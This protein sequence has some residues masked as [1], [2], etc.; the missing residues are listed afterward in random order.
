MTCALWSSTLLK[1]GVRAFGTKGELRVFNPTG[2]QFGYRM[3]VR[4]AGTKER[5][6]V[7]GAK[8][9]T[10][11]YQLRAFLAAVRDGDPA[12]HAT[13]RRRREHG[14]RRRDLPR[15]GPRCARAV[16]SRRL[17]TAREDPGHG[18]PSQCALRVPVPGGARARDDGLAA[19]RVRPDLRARR[20]RAGGAGPRADDGCPRGGAR[21]RWRDRGRRAAGERRL[22]L[23]DR[24]RRRHRRVGEPRVASPRVARPGARRDRRRV[25][26]QPPR[27]GEAARGELDT[28]PH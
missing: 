1:V 18:S 28:N 14:G 21:R 11:T 17:R 24:R 20:G 8:T 4:R 9:P 15:R 12:A 23:D 7:D 19:P 13:G 22:A 10:Y 26:R 27:A 6:R 3:T 2:P 25:Q 16:D 5:I